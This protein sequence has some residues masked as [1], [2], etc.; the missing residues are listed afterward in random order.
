MIKINLLPAAREAKKKETLKQQIGV[1]VLCLIL[2]FFFMGYLNASISKSISHLQSRI[3][4]IK[5]EIKQLDRIISQVKD[6]EKEKGTLERKLGIIKDLEEGKS[7]PVKMVDELSRATPRLVWLTSFSERDGRI[8]VE[9]MAYGNATIARF[10]SNLERSPL[11]TNVVFGSSSMIEKEGIKLV[12]FD[13]S[14]QMILP[15]AIAKKSQP[16]KK[17]KR[18]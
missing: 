15:E 9:G 18:R 2:L 4:D 3:R 6:I 16:A 5:R 1:V 12:K 7:L 11:F 17:G 10:I 14:F 8:R 13:L